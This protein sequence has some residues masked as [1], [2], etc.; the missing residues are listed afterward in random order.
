MDEN[1]T[2]RLHPERVLLRLCLLLL[3]TTWT[4]LLAWFFMGDRRV[5]T[6]ALYA[7]AATLIVASTPLVAFLV[8]S[9]I[10]RLRGDRH[11]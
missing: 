6:W 9:V 11:R 4:L 5:L 10:E 1:F 2:K 7:L 3:V 8:L